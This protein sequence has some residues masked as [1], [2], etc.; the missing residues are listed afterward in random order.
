[1]KLVI[2]NW[3]YALQL[4][5]ENELNFRELFLRSQ[6]QDYLEEIKQEH[7]ALFAGTLGE[8]LPFHV[9]YKQVQEHHLW[10]V[11]GIGEENKI[12]SWMDILTRQGIPFLVL[13]KDP[14]WY[15]ELKPQE[16]HLSKVDKE[17]LSTQNN[18]ARIGSV[19]HLYG[20]IDEKMA[21]RT[22]L[23][24]VLLHLDHNPLTLLVVPHTLVAPQSTP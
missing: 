5:G 15:C 24:M 21:S 4:L 20:C 9:L 13:T 2:N 10:K 22:G 3:K 7:P 14:V 17:I 1:M 12:K 16:A 11:P 23:D 8:A 6:N 19:I 18:A